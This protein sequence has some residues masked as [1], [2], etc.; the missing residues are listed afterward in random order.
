MTAI[1]DLGAE[2]EHLLRSGAVIPAHPLA[3]TAERTLDERRQRALTRYYA[4]AGADGIAVAV[5]TTQFEIRQ[6]KFGL[7]Q[8]VLEIGAEAFDESLA[9]RPGIKF[10]G[11]VGDTAQ[12]VREAELARNLGYDAVLVSP[13]GL[14]SVSEA[15]LLNRAAA[16]GEVLP[17]VGFYLQDAV[18]GRYLSRDFWRRLAD[19]EST[20]AIKAAPFDRYRT[21][22]VVQ[23]VALSHRGDDVLLYTGN[24]DS[25]VA[26][27]MTS[28][29]VPDG[30]G[31]L[32]Q[33]RFVGGLLGHWA[34]WTRAAV[35]LVEL[36]KRGLA[37]DASA[38][39][40]A[41]RRSAEVTD[42]NAAVFDARNHF[43]GV[44]AGVHE[45]L[46]RQRLLAGTWCLDPD[47]TL[48]PG[49]REL[50]GEVIAR[51][52]WLQAEDDFIAEHLDNWLA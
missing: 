37:G 46:F 29:R 6:P 31:R 41:G 34:V 15:Y 39:A 26:D 20:I 35:Q 4:A 24:D 28:Y 16:I 18:G 27:L 1:T 25:I 21:L 42:S 32:H 22:E 49:Q 17:V 33:R 3:L 14:A 5:H 45:V 43:A 7:L 8:P 12:A 10:A 2:K 47:E 51:Y 40:E 11:V 23:G 48:S 50:L 9:G 44:I 52:S 13:G 19:Q 36:I 38:S 30:A